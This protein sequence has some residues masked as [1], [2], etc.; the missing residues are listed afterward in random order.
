MAYKGFYRDMEIKNLKKVAQRILKAIENKEKI[1]LFSDSDLDGVTSLIILKETIENLGGKVKLVYFSFRE[2]GY[3][4]NKK[5]L[6]FLKSKAPALLICLDLGIG[7][8]EEVKLAKKYGFEVIIVDHHDI[9][10]KLPPASIIVDPKQKGDRSLFNFLANVGIVFKLSKEIL[11]KSLFKELEKSFLELAA[12]GTIAD[13]MPQ[14]GENKEIIEKGIESLKT[15]ERIGIRVFF[16]R[17]G[18]VPIWGLS[19]N[20]KTNS[21]SASRII[22]LLNAGQQEK[23]NLTETYLILSA[24]EISKARKILSILLRKNKKRKLKIKEII[25]EVE[26]RVSKQKPQP[27]VFEGKNNWSLVHLGSAASKI[28]Q[29][30]KKPIFLFKEK[31]NLILGSV[32]SPKGINNLEALKSCSKFLKTYGGHPQASGFYLK[33]ENL[34]RFKNC[35]IEYYNPNDTN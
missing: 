12:L 13:L 10:G 35:L 27:I 28:C 6:R 14:I 26:K 24:S 21:E 1:I 19:P 33:E 2:D 32:R 25:L 7:N 9:L 5:A 30:Y 23:D 4:L 22:S 15:S 34:E 17:K 18:T 16:E 8:F 31:K 20:S 29:K 3:G 11:P